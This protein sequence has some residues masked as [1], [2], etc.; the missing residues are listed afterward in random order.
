MLQVHCEHILAHL[1]GLHEIAVQYI[2]Q[3]EWYDL[4]SYVVVFQPSFIFNLL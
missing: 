4:T 1:R 2:T 3:L